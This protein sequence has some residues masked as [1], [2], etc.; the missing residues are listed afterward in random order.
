MNA[1]EEKV[2]TDNITRMEFELNK[3]LT[4]AGCLMQTIRDTRMAVTDPVMKRCGW[5]FD[6][7][8]EAFHQMAITVIYDIKSSI[9]EYGGG[10]TLEQS[11]RLERIAKALAGLK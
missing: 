8:L 4:K 2:V 7:E 9:T 1:L 11:A 5:G 3:H 6:D 10:V